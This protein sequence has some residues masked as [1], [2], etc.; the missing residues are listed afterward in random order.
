M[1]LPNAPAP[2]PTVASTSSALPSNLSPNDPNFVSI[3]NDRIRRVLDS[4]VT[5]QETSLRLSQNLSDVPDKEAARKNLAVLAIAKNLKDVKD[6][7]ESRKNLD[8]VKRITL[9]DPLGAATST[10]SAAQMGQVITLLG[11]IVNALQ[12]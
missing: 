10:Y 4:T 11:Q 2:L 5:V 12:H 9:V 8:V 3:V 1:A 7:A 6:V